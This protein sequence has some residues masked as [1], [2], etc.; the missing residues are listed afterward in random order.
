[1]IHGIGLEEEGPTVGHPGDP[2]PTPDRVIEENVALV[3]ELY[4][5]EVGAT[6]GVK[7]GDQGVVTAQG[8][9]VLAPFPF[10]DRLGEAPAPSD[11][12]GPSV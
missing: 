2:Q 10:D 11:R 12:V 3:V 9:R 6:H 5:G 1:M 7:L 4:A 8:F